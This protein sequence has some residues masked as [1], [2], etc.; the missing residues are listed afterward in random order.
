ME[1]RTRIIFWIIAFVALV[2]FFATSMGG[3][4]SFY[5]VSA[6]LPIMA[7]ASFSFNS[8]L[9]PRYLLTGRKLKFVLYTFYLLVI[10]VY[11]QLCVI[12]LAL[13]MLANYSFPEL[14]QYAGDIRLLMVLQFLLVFGDGFL[15][16]WQSLKKRDQELAEL[17]AMFEKE[18]QEILEVTVNRQ[19]VRLPLKDIY[20]VE[21]F[22]DYVKIHLETRRV[23]VR[24]KI[25][26]LQDRLPQNFVR[27]H[28]SYLINRNQ[29]TAFNK[30]QISFSDINIPIGRKY[31]Q[32]VLEQLD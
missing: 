27:V 26:K 4:L 5:F 7:I 14:G 29:M 23:I 18:E 12:I 13:I 24:D 20:Y 6:L 31:A 8:F 25:S 17:K 3:I 1:S 32:E 10:A 30:S 2:A 19:K 22:S 11:L 21:S 9:V 16:S 15:L 28:R